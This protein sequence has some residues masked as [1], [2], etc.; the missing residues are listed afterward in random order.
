MIKCAIIEQKLEKIDCGSS[1]T[2]S[3]E[4]DK[5]FA[6]EGAAQFSIEL[7]KAI[8]HLIRNEGEQSDDNLVRLL[9]I[10]AHGMEKT[11]TELDAGLDESVDFDMLREYFYVLPANLVIYLHVC[12]GTFPAAAAMTSGISGVPIVVGP[13]VAIYKT[14]SEEFLAE[15]RK[16][17]SNGISV[18]EIRKIIDAWNSDRNNHSRYGTDHIFGMHLADGGFHPEDARGHLAAPI[19]PREDFEICSFQLVNDLPNAHCVLRSKER[20]DVEYLTPTSNIPFPGEGNID[21]NKFDVNPYIGW[22]VSSRYQKVDETLKQL[23][24]CSIV[25]VNPKIR[26]P[27]GSRKDGG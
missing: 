14:N 18:D 17:L 8:Q 19:E 13:L 7:T 2:E 6:F 11:G 21:L 4:P 26:K 12:W 23:D 1:M 9:V 5:R 24:Y 16:S 20:P 3:V 10:S 15:L 27:H 25:L 22:K